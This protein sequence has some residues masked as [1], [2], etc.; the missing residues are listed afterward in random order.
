MKDAWFL[1]KALRYWCFWAALQAKHLL[2][3]SF[4]TPPFHAN[5]CRPY[6][7]V[8]FLCELR[9]I[10]RYSCVLNR[11]G[12]FFVDILQEFQSQIRVTNVCWHVVPLSKCP[13]H[14]RL[15]LNSQPSFQRPNS[16]QTPSMQ[17]L[18]ATPRPFAGALE[19]NVFEGLEGQPRERIWRKINHGRLIYV[20]Y[21]V[22]R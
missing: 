3:V 15:P 18:H 19:G 17:T 22:C 8:L 13:V 14:V 5:Q 4:D 9:L 1:K 20:L 21:R 12:C 6:M 7:N 10:L 2:P 11:P 16:R